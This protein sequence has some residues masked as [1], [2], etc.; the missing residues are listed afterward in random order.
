LKENTKTYGL[1]NKLSGFILP[2]F[3]PWVA[4]LNLLGLLLRSTPNEPDISKLIIRM[5]YCSK[6]TNNVKTI[7]QKKILTESQHKT[8]LLVETRVILSYLFKAI[9]KCALIQN[10]FFIVAFLL[11]SGLKFFESWKCPPESWFL[12]G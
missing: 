3:C 6:K 2:V 4:V 9:G 5:K 11:P 8:R 10:I 12:F 7:Q 1:L